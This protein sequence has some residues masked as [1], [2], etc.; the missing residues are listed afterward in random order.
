MGFMDLFIQNEES[1]PAKPGP[2]PT[3]VRPTAPPPSPISTSQAQPPLAPAQF[4]ALVD[5]EFNAAA[6]PHLSVYF[7]IEEGFRQKVVDPAQRAQLVLTAMTAQGHSTAA[8][9]TDIQEA[10]AALQNVSA[11][12]QSAREAALSSAVTAREQQAA[13]NRKRAADLRKE[14]DDLDKAAITI[15]SEARTQRSAID[16]NFAGVTAY[17]NQRGQELNAA[18][19]HIQGAS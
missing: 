10:Q 13:A 2:L 11:K 14:A 17:I 4:Q 5:E 7:K 18:A 6:A 3:A 8:I 1:K 19:Q 15:E 16:N 12:M 9:L